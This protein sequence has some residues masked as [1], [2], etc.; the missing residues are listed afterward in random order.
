V[1]KISLNLKTKP[2]AE[3]NKTGNRQ[4]AME[5]FM[6]NTE[7]IDKVRKQALNKIEKSERQYKLAFFCACVIETTFVVA[8]FFLADFS[9]RMHL[10]LFISVI[11]TYT[12]IGMGL[13]ALG[14]HINKSV[15]RI[16]QAIETTELPRRED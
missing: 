4:S 5:Y 13:F 14:A 16:L 11:A 9:N 12:I 3:G 7:N 15:G 1:K 2:I 8:F 10:L 6:V